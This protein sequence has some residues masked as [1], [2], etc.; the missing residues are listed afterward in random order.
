MIPILQTEKRRHREVMN[1][2]GSS[3]LQAAG[4]GFEARK[5]SFGVPSCSEPLSPPPQKW[6]VLQKGEGR[7]PRGPLLHL[8]L[9]PDLA[10]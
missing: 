10:L 5:E 7:G 1:C 9:P 2:L 8:L 4:L 6:E 3:D